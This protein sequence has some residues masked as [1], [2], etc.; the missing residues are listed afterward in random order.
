MTSHSNDTPAAPGHPRDKD[1]PQHAAWAEAIRQSMLKR[2]EKAPAKE[3][4]K[5]AKRASEISS[6]RWNK[7]QWRS[8]KARSEFAAYVSSHVKDRTAG[9]RPRSQD[10]C[11]C[12]RYTQGY[13]AKR[14]HRC[15]AA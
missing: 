5:V 6:A 15:V 7:R 4:A 1:H 12:G 2:W 9:G 14:N 11:P 10:R 13:A 3:R 8:K